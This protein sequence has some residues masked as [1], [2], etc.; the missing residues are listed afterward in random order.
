MF[1]VVFPALFCVS[2]TDEGVLFPVAGCTVVPV[3]VVL[4][5][6]AKGEN[7]GVLAVKYKYLS[8]SP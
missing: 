5:V 1:A 2:S 7:P 3:A 6:I 8:S 4:P